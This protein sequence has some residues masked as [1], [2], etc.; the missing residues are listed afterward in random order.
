[1]PAPRVWTETERQQI[2]AGR[3]RGEFWGDMAPRFGVH[4]TTLVNAAKKMGVWTP[5]KRTG[6]VT[7][8][9]RPFADRDRNWWP[10]PPG[11]PETWGAITRG[12]VLEGA[13]YPV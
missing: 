4:R 7:A 9:P 11:S 13:E 3:K 5:D 8:T 1:M 6:Q 2:I 10:L 12:T